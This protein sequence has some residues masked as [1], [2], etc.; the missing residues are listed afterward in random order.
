M[1]YRLV[2]QNN[3]VSLIEIKS[4]ELKDITGKTLVDVDSSKINVLNY[5]RIVSA[6]EPTGFK[7]GEIVLFQ[8]LAAHKTS[9]GIPSELIVPVEHIEAKLSEE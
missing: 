3:N 7:E 8:K 5:G 2:P 9:F 6:P 4:K 1:K